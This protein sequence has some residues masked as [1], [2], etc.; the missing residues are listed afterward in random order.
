MKFSA[1]HSILVSLLMFGQWEQAF[2][3][4]RAG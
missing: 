3:Q 1:R 2:A 4:D